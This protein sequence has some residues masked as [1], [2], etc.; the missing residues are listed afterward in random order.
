MI[1]QQEARKTR[2]PLLKPEMKP[3]LRAKR[4][5]QKSVKKPHCAPPSAKTK[6]VVL[7]A[8]VACVET[9][10]LEACAMTSLELA[11][12]CQIAKKKDVETMVAEVPAAVVMPTKNVQQPAN[13]SAHP[14]A[15]EKNVGMTDVAAPAETAPWDSSVEKTI[16]A[17]TPPVSPT[18]LEK[19]AGMTD[20]VA[21]VEIAGLD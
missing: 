9:A 8:V 17:A 3:F 13:V 7:T 10:P 20:V 14:S 11:N 6:T 19:P 1:H 18:A 5:A 15:T 4:S 12:A 16:F 21:P 2:R